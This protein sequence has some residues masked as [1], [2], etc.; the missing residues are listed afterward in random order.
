MTNVNYFYDVSCESSPSATR[1]ICSA[2]GATPTG[3]VVIASPSGP[4]GSWT[5]TTPSSLPGAIVNG[6]PLDT[7]SDS[8]HWTS[9]SPGANQPNATA[10]SNL[11]PQSSGYSV[12]ASDCSTGVTNTTTLNALPG[13]TTSTTVPVGFLPLDIVT[14]ATKAPVVG[15]TVKLTSTTANCGADTYTMP[16]TDAYG[17]TQTSVPFGTYSYTVTTAGG[18]SSPIRPR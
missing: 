10:L 13:G 15:A 7:S 5:T 6:I 2:V 9:Y 17:L 3:P 14:T 11:Y 18:V 1:A 12:A 4:A 8:L 16:V